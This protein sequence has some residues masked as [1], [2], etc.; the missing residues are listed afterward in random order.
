M[1]KTYSILTLAAALPFLTPMPA[2]ACFALDCG[3]AFHLQSEAEYSRQAALLR[4]NSELPSSIGNSA[5]PN[6]RDPLPFSE[7]IS[8]TLMQVFVTDE[9]TECPR[10]WGAIDCPVVVHGDGT[11]EGMVIANYTHDG[12]DFVTVERIEYPQSVTFTDAW[13]VYFVAVEG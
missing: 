3:P 11:R 9:R 1:K 13:P 7:P 12:A 8:R 10:I 5:Q 4:A 2:E 6:P